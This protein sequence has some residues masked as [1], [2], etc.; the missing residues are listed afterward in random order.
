LAILNLTELNFHIVPDIAY[1]VLKGD[2]NQP[3]VRS[4]KKVALYLSCCI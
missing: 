1:F 3:Y 4:R 2:V